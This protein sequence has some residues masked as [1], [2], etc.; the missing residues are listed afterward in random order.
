MEHEM[1]HRGLRATRQTMKRRPGRL[2]P[3]EKKTVYLE[4]SVVS[5]LTNRRAAI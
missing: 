4:T 3:V 5:Y 2:P 1:A